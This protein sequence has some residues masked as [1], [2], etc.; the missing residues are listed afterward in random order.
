MRRPAVLVPLLVLACVVPA[1]AA[2]GLVSVG[3]PYVR[4]CPQAGREDRIDRWLM[5]TCNCTSYAAWALA[6]N[7]YRT[8]WFVPGAMD[9]W[10]WPNVARRKGIAV[11]LRPR[12]GAVAVWPEWGR[13]GHLA[14]VVAVHPDGRFD[15]AEYNTP[16]HERFGFDR[17][18]GIRPGDDVTFLYVPRR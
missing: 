14:F 16:G 17:R 4:S 6:R 8:D 1:V 3:Y 7:G 18:T 15:V 11:G 2:G 10:N 13:F 12:P 5:N 9:A